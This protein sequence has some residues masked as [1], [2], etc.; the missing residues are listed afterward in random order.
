MPIHFPF[1][2]FPNFQTSILAETISGPIKRRKA[3]PEEPSLPRSNS[4]PFLDLVSLHSQ[5]TLVR[6]FPSPSAYPHRA[7]ST[8]TIPFQPSKW[9]PLRANLPPPPTVAPNHARRTS[10]PKN[11][12][13]RNKPRER[14]ESEIGRENGN[15][16]STNPSSTSRRSMS[17]SSMSRSS[18]SRRL[19]G[20]VIRIMTSNWELRMGACLEFAGGGYPKKIK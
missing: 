1:F 9:A 11:E 5:F 17:R 14:N 10:T 3:G 13:A 18:M 8:T 7:A 6:P 16:P 2:S 20:G 12:A 4:E 15:G 19:R